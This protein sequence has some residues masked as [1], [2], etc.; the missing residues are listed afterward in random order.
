MWGVVNEGGTGWRARVLGVE[1]CG[2][3]G[4]AQVASRSN[5]QQASDGSRP[6]HLRNH[7]WF[8]G[9]APKGNPEIAVAVL[10]E[11]GGAG[12]QAAA[13]VAQRIFQAYFDGRSKV[14]SRNVRQASLVG[15]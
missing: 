15:N 5:L 3:T 13:P 8:V 2:K 10:V 9:Y 6:E 14:K 12:G 11:H 7:G 4:T 1:V